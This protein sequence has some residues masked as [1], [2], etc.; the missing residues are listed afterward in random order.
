ML[1][2]FTLPLRLTILLFCFAHATL[3]AQDG[4]LDSSFGTKARVF[5]PAGAYSGAPRI[6]TLADHKILHIGQVAG[7][8][9]IVRYTENGSIDAS[10]GNNGIRTFAEPGFPTGAA[11]QP[12]GKI[13]I[14][15]SSGG[16]LALLRLNADG[17]PDGGFDGDG[18]ATS[19]AAPA[20]NALALQP[21]GKIVAVGT[22]NAGSDPYMVAVRFLQDGSMD[23]GFDGDG[24]ATFNVNPGIGNQ[25]RKTEQAF[26]VAIQQDE[27]ILLG[28][29]MINW[30]NTG[31]YYVYMPNGVV[32]RMNPDGSRDTGFGNN[33]VVDFP[34]YL[35]TG[36]ITAIQQHPD[37]RI[38]AGLYESYDLDSHFP[39]IQ[40]LSPDGQL[41]KSNSFTTAQ[42]GLVDLA[43][44]S[45]GKVLISGWM[46]CYPCSGS[47]G[48]NF[49]I[50]RYLP[51]GNA[52]LSFGNRGVLNFEYN[53]ERVFGK[54]NWYTHEVGGSLASQGN[55]LLI[56][57]YVGL[58]SVENFNGG[59]NTYVY[60]HRRAAIYRLHNSS[61]LLPDN[62]LFYYQDVDQDGYGNPAQT[63]VAF[64]RPPGAVMRGGDCNDASASVYPGAPEVLNGIDDNCNGQVDEGL[65]QGAYV[66]IP[67]RIEAENYAAMH[68]VQKEP[69]SDQGGGQ[70]VGYIDWG[71]W[72]DYNITVPSTGNYMISFRLATPSISNPEFQVQTSNDRLLA[73][74]QV[75]N[76]GG[77]QNWTTHSIVVHLFS[78]NQTIRLRSTGGGYWN[79]N[80]LELAHPT[81]HHPI[82]GR[83]EAESYSS[84]QGTQVE[85]T[86]DQEGGQNV[87]YI[88]MF[89]YLDYNVNVTTPGTFRVYFRVASSMSG[90]QF[91]VRTGTG[92]RLAQVNVPNTGGWQNWTNV[93]ILLNLPQGNHTLRIVST[94]TA[95]WNLNY[96]VF[97]QGQYPVP[98]P[99]KM[100][101]EYV[102]GMSGVQIERAY[103][104][105]VQGQFPGWEDYNVGYIDQGDWME[106]NITVPPGGGT[107]TFSARVASQMSGGQFEVRL[108]NGT[109]LAKINVPNTGGWQNWTTVTDGS[110]FTLPEGN[111]AIRITSTSIANW[112]VNWIDFSSASGYYTKAKPGLEET[113]ETRDGSSV[114][115]YPN[116]VR[117]AFNL[118]L[119]STFTGAVRVEVISISGRMEKRFTL[120]KASGK[121]R[122]ALSL[123]GLAKG[124]YMLR[125]TSGGVTQTR[126]LIKL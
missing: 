5:E 78:G 85:R 75:P 99:A 23:P 17:T 28:G 11:L 95:N 110:I 102:Q 115:L 40:I 118:E 54:G 53:S 108:K 59:E 25:N 9:R 80:W 47:R 1:T 100:Q 62:P 111:H 105:E 18:K 64:T 77:F 32:A 87:G 88:D 93:H 3:R 116:P 107:F 16:S 20:A 112:N 68:G 60:D 30:V 83:I 45:D 65:N 106:Y 94:S 19:T 124:E 27:K 70:N 46:N 22:G 122:H 126:K 35:Y 109:L 2:K 38:F 33:G 21:D 58:D 29:E 10:F 72:M 92:E 39:G 57:G 41:I 101:A 123:S 12:D 91:E 125:I 113:T 98:V 121:S 44:Q 86:T 50:A 14:S 56:G 89:D 51:D 15:G 82:P 74:V 48:D 52:D 117:D 79:I 104:P 66:R 96:I 84:Q 8:L 55:K 69:T 90:G 13:L 43:I 103:D 73:T 26:A 114:A 63:M 7:M 42:G 81:T 71:D 97:N 49:F 36:K 31:P 37:G 34:D 24:T 76:T 120:N 6:L 67:A 119:N 4:K 61:P